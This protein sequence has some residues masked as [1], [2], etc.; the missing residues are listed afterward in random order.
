[1]KEYVYLLNAEDAFF[2]KNSYSE[3]TSFNWVHCEIH[4]K[5]STADST[6]VI[7]TMIET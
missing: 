7:H 5:E 4:Y 2:E 1:M 6:T 3:P